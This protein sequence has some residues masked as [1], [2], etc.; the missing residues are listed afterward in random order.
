MYM[1]IV[2]YQKEGK[3]FKTHYR[4][5]DRSCMHYLII[6]IIIMKMSW[7]DMTQN[8]YH[9]LTEAWV[10]YVYHTIEY[11]NK[12][13]IAFNHSWLSGLCMYAMKVKKS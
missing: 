6:I 2:F 4:Y 1:Y 9:L 12:S 7:R 5:I 10:G 8:V 11:F 3:L 13:H